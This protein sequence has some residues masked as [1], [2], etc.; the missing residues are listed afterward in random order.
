[1]SNFILPDLGEG[2]AEAEIREWYVK[3]GDVVKHEQ[4]L[5]S[6]ETAKALVD[7]PS[8]QAGKIEKLFGKAGDIINVGE[9]LISFVDDATSTPKETKTKTDDGT[10]VGKLETSERVLK[11]SATGITPAQSNKETVKATPA[12][13]ALAQSLQVDLTTIKPTGYNQ[14]ITLEDV[15]QAAK[16]PSSS[17]QPKTT[18]ITPASS[19][20]AENTVLLRGARRTMV[21]SMTSAQNEIVPVT[22]MDQA[23]I[24]AW[25]H[26]TDFTLRIVR[27]IAHACKIEPALNAHFDGKQL[28]KKLFSEINLGIAVDTADSLYVP[29]LKNVM[30]QS[31]EALRKEINHFKSA[32]QERNFPLAMLQDA[33]ITLSN[34]GTIA[35]RYSN[36]IVVPPTVAIVGIGKAFLDTVAKHD[37]IA[38]H[39]ILPLSLT[40]DH[41]ACTGGEAARFLAALIE[42]LEK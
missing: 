8:P 40:I 9:P 4:P 3:E 6:V 26:N 14:T 25:P 2:L 41:R 11:E 38:I 33:T 37:Q 15:Q 22:L 34:F 24:Q 5:V 35:G 17:S 42:D 12:V 16:L 23:D 7:I 20:K 36:P 1:M 19:L 13:R 30:Q 18:K 29:V 31:D 39:R 21:Q 10:V 27:A 28:E 32:A